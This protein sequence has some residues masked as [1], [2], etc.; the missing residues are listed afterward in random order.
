MK[1]FLDSD[2]LHPWP[3]TVQRADYKAKVGENDIVSF[4]VVATLTAQPDRPLPRLGV[5]GT[6]QV[7]GDDVSLGLFLFRRPITYLRQWVGL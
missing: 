2:P 5:R 1:L 6:A 3:A 7:S 4:R